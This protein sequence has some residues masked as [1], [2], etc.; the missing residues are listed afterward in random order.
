MRC[1][2]C[3]YTKSFLARNGLSRLCLKGVPS[4][5]Y[6]RFAWILPPFGRQNDGWLIAVGEPL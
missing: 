1:L 4:P 5:D 3:R 2:S 6:R